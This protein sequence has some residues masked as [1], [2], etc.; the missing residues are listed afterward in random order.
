MPMTHLH[1][2]ILYRMVY[3][4]TIFCDSR[5]V[6]YLATHALPNSLP[7]WPQTS[8][9]PGILLLLLVEQ[10]HLRQWA[11]SR[12]PKNTFIPLESFQESYLL[13]IGTICDVIQR[14]LR[15][16]ASSQ[17]PVVVEHYSFAP[18]SDFWNGMNLVLR[19]LP[20]KWLAGS[21]EKPVELRRAI[22]NHL[23]VQKTRS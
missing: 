14:Q 10:N 23:R 3:N 9:P 18:P 7:G 8:I 5:V 4:W 12:L 20:P 15:D 19:L 6:S 21:S 2:A 13:A 11:I 16:S 17:V 1:P 22:M